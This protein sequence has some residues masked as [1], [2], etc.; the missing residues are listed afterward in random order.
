MATSDTTKPSEKIA[1]V[2]KLYAEINRGQSADAVIRLLDPLMEER[3]GQL[4]NKFRQCPPE[5]G[6]LLDLKAQITEVWN[7]RE[8]LKNAVKLGMSAQLIL[9]TVMQKS[10]SSGNRT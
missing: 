6:P 8:V 2:D 9:E 1:K 5:L 3:L 4:L 7:I 10:T